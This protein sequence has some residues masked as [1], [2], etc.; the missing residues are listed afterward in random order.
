MYNRMLSW[1]Y[2]I[3]TATGNDAPGRDGMQWSVSTYHVVV[4]QQILQPHSTSETRTGLVCVH[5][6]QIHQPPPNRTGSA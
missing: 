3:A 6:P 4:R 5:H 2:T 1:G